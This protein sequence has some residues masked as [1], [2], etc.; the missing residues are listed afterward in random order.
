MGKVPYLQYGEVCLTRTLS[1]TLE[2][3]LS[4]GFATH[5]AVYTTKFRRKRVELLI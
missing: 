2:V 1:K 3:L 5:C 4:C